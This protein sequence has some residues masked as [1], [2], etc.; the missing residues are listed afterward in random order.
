MHLKRALLVLLLILVPLLGHAASTPPPAGSSAVDVVKF[1]VGYENRAADANKLLRGSSNKPT[2]L[3]TL[4]FTKDFL[5]AW[6]AIKAKETANPDVVFTPNGTP[7]IDN[8]TNGETDYIIS[9]A[10]DGQT[11]A[12]I[13]F[14]SLS[15][16]SNGSVVGVTYRTNGTYATLFFLK[17]EDGRFKIDDISL[18]S[19]D[20]PSFDPK[21]A[22]QPGVSEGVR[23]DIVTALNNFKSL[24][25]K[26]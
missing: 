16:D 13:K 21:E 25:K 20:K 1:V 9:D 18:G 3:E 2:Q 26:P 11:P 6:Y 10:P 24:D 17:L 22:H 5:A 4:L 15:S 23:K 7:G 19:S 8:V 14:K 12:A